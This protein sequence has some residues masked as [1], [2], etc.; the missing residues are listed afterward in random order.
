MLKIYIWLKSI[1][2]FHAKWAKLVLQGKGTNVDGNKSRSKGQRQI[3]KAYRQGGR[4]EQARYMHSTTLTG[5]R[6]YWFLDLP[7]WWLWNTHMGRVM[8]DLVIIM[9]F[10]LF[11]GMEH[12]VHVEPSVNTLK[13]TDMISAGHKRNPLL[14]DTCF[15]F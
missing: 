6:W 10:S 12:V 3:E 2:S 1:Q 4:T 9:N 8:Y 11:F 15:D 5:S 13:R 7:H 14:H